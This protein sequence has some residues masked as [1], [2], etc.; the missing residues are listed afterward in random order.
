MRGVVRGLGVVLLVAGLG[1][2]G[3]VG[4]QYV[5]TGIT[6]NQ[7]MTDGENSLR[8]QWKAPAQAA[9][10][11]RAGKPFVLLRIPRFGADWV[12]PVVEGVDADD[13][14]R[15]IGHYPQTQLPGQP[16]NFAVAGHR[17]THGSP[18]RK[19]LEL[20]K[21]DQ[22]LVE[23]QD[24]VYTYELDGSPRDLT[25]EAS[26]TWVLDPVPGQRQTPTRSIITLTTCQDLF[27][28]PDRSVAFG[29]LVKVTKK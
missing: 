9:V 2:L 20:S 24:A 23:T 21:G 6:S 8:G 3:W 29:H 14:S 7:K 22:V 12:K 27:H 1:V 11:P 28:S 13:L 26:E 10:T 18:F 16:G 17:V 5:G 15:G 4:W 25:V 19:L